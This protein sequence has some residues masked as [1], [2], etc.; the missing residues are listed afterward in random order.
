MRQTAA[1][2]RSINFSCLVIVKLPC[3][4]RWT[5]V[6]RSTCFAN[7]DQSAFERERSQ[8]TEEHLFQQRFTDIAKSCGGHQDIDCGGHKDKL[9]SKG[10]NKED[11]AACS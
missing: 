1:D 8:L 2:R 6:H 5:G 4:R 9:Q 7:V 3:S 11:F 10:R